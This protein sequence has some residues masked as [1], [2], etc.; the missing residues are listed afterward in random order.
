[1]GCHVPFE[2][3]AAKPIPAVN[4]EA[5]SVVQIS[6]GDLVKPNNGKK[7]LQALQKDNARL[8]EKVKKLK[9]EGKQAAVESVKEIK[10]LKELLEVRLRENKLQHTVLTM[11]N[12]TLI[13]FPLYRFIELF[14]FQILCKFQV[15][16][17][18][19]KMQIFTCKF[20]KGATN[21]FWKFLQI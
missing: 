10:Y 9:Q 17:F 20:Q 3:T 12:F 21:E 14:Y 4:A 19:R 18:P 15:C 16:K 2:T 6:S 11:R 5:T 7:D 13:R 8:R 1:M